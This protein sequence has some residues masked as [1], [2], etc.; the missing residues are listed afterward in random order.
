MLSFNLS[1]DGFKF[2]IFTYSL[3]KLQFTSPTQR[4]FVVQKG[5]RPKANRKEWKGRDC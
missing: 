5:W 3:T 4:N 1:K 2:C